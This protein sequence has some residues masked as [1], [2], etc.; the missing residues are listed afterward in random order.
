MEL[1]FRALALVSIGGALGAPSRFALSVLI[2]RTIHGPTFPYATLSVNVAG[3]FLLALLAWTAGGRFGLSEST[4]L[5]LGTGMMGAFT[6]FSTFSVET[7]L[8]I[9]ESRHL[10]AAL[11]VFTS[12]ILCLSAA[13]L[14]MTLAR[15]IT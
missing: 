7:L 15:T 2:T 1:T 12:V 5:L 6:T 14:G 11:Y 9:D 4:R 3:S 8:L 13:Y 10:T